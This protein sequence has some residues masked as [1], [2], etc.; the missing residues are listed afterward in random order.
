MANPF[1]T[2]PVEIY[3]CPRTG[4]ATSGYG[5]GLIDLL[6]YPSPGAM[7]FLGYCEK[8]PRVLINP[9]WIPL[10][11]DLNGGQVP[12]DVSCA[13]S[14]AMISMTLTVWNEQV[15]KPLVATPRGFSSTRGFWAAADV[16]RLMLHEAYATA[17]WCYFPYSTLKPFGAAFFQPA[18]YHFIATW[19]TGEEIE[20]GS[21]LSKR[22]LQLYAVPVYNPTNGTWT[23]YDHTMTHIPA[24]PPYLPSGALT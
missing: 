24:I 5:G 1:S 18:G 14:D 13:V 17:V 21:K 9:K 7:Y 10:L 15:Y 3:V 20:S 16:G 11:S 8:A 2:G 22:L 6:T 19:P 4:V 12:F 23:L